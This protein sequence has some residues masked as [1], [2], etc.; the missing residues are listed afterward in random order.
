[1]LMIKTP[2]I[3]AGDTVAMKYEAI[4]IYGLTGR[5]GKRVKRQYL[6]LVQLLTALIVGKLQGSIRALMM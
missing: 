6:L 2:I 3:M 4:L 5:P 1:M